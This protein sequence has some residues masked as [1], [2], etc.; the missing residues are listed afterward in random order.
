MVDRQ[1]QEALNRTTDDA[2]KERLRMI[3]EKERMLH[4]MVEMKN[5][6]E[7]RNIASV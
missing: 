2:E 1:I 5:T 7:G 4:E 3:Q 6:I